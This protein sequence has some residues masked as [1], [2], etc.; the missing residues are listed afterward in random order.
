M[1]YTLVFAKARPSLPSSALSQILLCG[2]RE[3]PWFLHTIPLYTPGCMC[4]L[5]FR[6]APTCYFSHS[7]QILHKIQLEQKKVFGRMDLITANRWNRSCPRAI[8]QCNYFDK[9]IQNLLPSGNTVW[10]Y[11]AILFDCNWKLDQ[12]NYLAAF[13]PVSIAVLSMLKNC[14]LKFR[15]LAIVVFRT[16]KMKIKIW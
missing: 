14:G 16:A 6:A 12:I 11:F 1:L 10:R 2:V 3:G 4:V 7:C 13:V 9:L 5:Y 8:D 15:H